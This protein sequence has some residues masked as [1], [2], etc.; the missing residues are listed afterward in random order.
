M[1]KQPTPDTAALPRLLTPKEAASMLAIS[2][3]SLWS[4][5]ASH[6]IPHVRFGRSV[7]YCVPDLLAWIDARKVGADKKG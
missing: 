1:N 4:L 5:T 2:A 6:E 3:R 7:R